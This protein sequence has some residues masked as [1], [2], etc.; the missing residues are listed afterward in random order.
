MR[1]MKLAYS[2]T[3]DR[4]VSHR[5]MPKGRRLIMVIGDVNGTIES[6]KAM[7]ELGLL[8]TAM[9]AMMPIITGIVAMDE[10]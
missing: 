1:N 3:S 7:D 5:G 6:Q 8:I 9:D 2:T 4:I 10:S